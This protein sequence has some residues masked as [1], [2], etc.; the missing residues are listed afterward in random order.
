ME[1]MLKYRTDMRDPATGHHCI[2]VIWSL[3]PGVFAHISRHTHMRYLLSLLLAL[4]QMFTPPFAVCKLVRILQ[5][6][7]ARHNP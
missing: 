5:A 7:A 1:L 2:S 6:S 3:V 4:A